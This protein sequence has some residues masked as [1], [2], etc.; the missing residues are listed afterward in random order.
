MTHTHTHIDLCLH[1]NQSKMFNSNSC[2]HRGEPEGEILH[3]RNLMHIHINH[4]GCFS[5]L[6][7][8]LLG[9]LDQIQSTEK[10]SYV[11][12]VNSKPRGVTLR[13]IAA[14]GYNTVLGI[15]QIHLKI[16]KTDSFVALHKP[17]SGNSWI[18]SSQNQVFLFFS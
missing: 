17:I 4:S 3:K 9:L 18:T 16:L 5:A 7:M 14:L 8:S 12:N 2:S 1:F 11:W 15:M 6:H 10:G 13:V